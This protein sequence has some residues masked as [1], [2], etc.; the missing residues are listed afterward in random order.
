[1]PSAP[2]ISRPIDVGAIPATGIERRFTANEAERAALARAYGLREVRAFAADLVA[3]A[4]GRGSILVDGRVTA[5]IVQD[6]V[7]SLEPVE[8]AIDE[9]VSVRFAPERA[10]DA[11]RSGEIEVD[12]DAE[13][14]PEP[15]SGSSI[16]LGAL[17]EE[18]FVLAIDPYPRAPGAEIPAKSGDDP[19]AESD[20]PFAALAALRG[21]PR[22]GR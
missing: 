7:V 22:D 16:D 1:M 20:S 14:P 8:Q 13:D 4:A 21:G 15:L 10:E 5:E 17:A 12:L 19:D 18:Y 3:T 6:C 2:V 11:G 9:T